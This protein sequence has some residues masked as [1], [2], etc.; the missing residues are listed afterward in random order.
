MIHF[1]YWEFDSPD[2]AGSGECMDS[3]FLEILD[4][5]REESK[6]KMRVNSGYRTK[7]HNAKVGGSPNSSHMKGIAADISCKDSQERKKL[8]FA[9]LDNG[10]KRIG[11][12]KTFLHFDSDDSKVSAI[13]VY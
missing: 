1:D 3:G 10:I 13:W 6:M 4:K 8:I 9:A 5:I 12:S 7:M 2:M 11:I